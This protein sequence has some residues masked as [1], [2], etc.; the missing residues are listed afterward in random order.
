VDANSNGRYEFTIPKGMYVLTATAPGFKPGSLQASAAIPIA[1]GQRK[2]GLDIVL[3]PGGVRIAGVV[4]DITGGP[5]AGAEIRVTRIEEPRMSVLSTSAHDGRF[6]LWGLAG[7]VLLKAAA[8]GYVATVARRVIPTGDIVIELTPGSSVEGHV[9]SGTD[10]SPVA[11]I[12]VSAVAMKRAFGSVA[13]L[14]AST[15]SD[16]AFKIHGLEPGVYRLFAQGRG[17]S[18]SSSE[19]YRLGLADAVS[20]ITVTVSAS[21]QVSGRVLRRSDSSGCDKGVVNF[22]P[23]GSRTFYDPPSVVFDPDPSHRSQVTSLSA[24]LEAD[25][26]VHF[27]AVPAG[28]YHVEVKCVDHLLVEG[29]TSLE[30]TTSNVSNLLWKVSTGIGL[31]VHMVDEAGQPLP[32]ATSWLTSAT[33]PV[34]MS[35]VA[36]SKGLFDHPRM[37]F[38][39]HYTLTP[40][41]GG[42]DGGPV[43]IELREGMEKVDVTVR[44][45]GQ[46]AIIASVRG[47]HSEPIDDLLVRAVSVM[48]YKPGSEPAFDDPTAPRERPYDAVALGDGRF[49]IPHLPR[50]E[51]R[52]QAADGVNPPFEAGGPAGGT[53][54]V[55]TEVTHVTITVDRSANIRGRVVDAAGQPMPDTW[56]SASCKPSE[57][58][59][60]PTLAF[61]P[62][63]RP[64]TNKRTI[65]N[66][67]GQFTLNDL[68]PHTLCTVRAEQPFDLLGTKENVPAGVSD[69]LVGLAPVEPSPSSGSTSS[70]PGRSS[71]VAP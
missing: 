16:G 4:L 32:Q 34:R 26:S 9:V 36:D 50:G 66:Q 42:S 37:L 61:G 48:H 33:S 12:E 38:P 54:Q 30:V 69:V 63:L 18:G 5:I 49:R 47:S 3:E 11:D 65:T 31:L 64:F 58:E 52:V 40:G 59:A 28:T 29:P 70:E 44:F 21:A 57:L 56:V 46:F 6:E 7:H 41:H 13:N 15:D 60:R 51:Y 10:R 2:T 14:P 23:T 17:F 35:L 25:G 1:D 55:S 19:T 27:S 67:E 8:D 22:G 24:P 43:D 71:A 68:A 53:F 45:K 62:R 39:G 20:N